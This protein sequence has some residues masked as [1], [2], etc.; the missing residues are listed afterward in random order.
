MGM[1]IAEGRS[2]RDSDGPDAARVAIVNATLAQALLRGSERRWRAP[3]FAGSTDKPLEIV[4]VVADTRTE[5]LSEPAEPEIYLP[6]WQSGAFSKHLVVRAT[7][8][9]TA[10][11]TLVR[12]ELRKL[13]P[14]SAVERMTTMAEIRRESVAPR[15]FAM[16]L[17]IGFAVVATVLALVGLY[18]VLSLS[19][20]SRIKEIAVRKAVG[21]QRHQIVQL[22]VGE[23]SKLVAGGLVF[24]A[25]VAVLVGRLLR[26]L[27]FDV[28]PS[29]PMALATGGD[30]VRSSGVC[31]LPRARVS[32]EPRRS[33]GIAASGLRG[34]SRW[35]PDAASVTEPTS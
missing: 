4:G 19:V 25:I 34:R 3:Q 35:G 24:G 1:R 20:S 10:L 18:G 5:D 30:R 8:D 6:F 23:G 28:T 31:R 15:T 33:H 2:F 16:R 7:G 26:T 32:G 9:P 22:V 27:L 11:A 14:T 21:A 17:L 29:D 13:D 12:G